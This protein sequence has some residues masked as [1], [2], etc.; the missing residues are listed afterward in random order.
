MNSNNVVEFKN[1]NNKNN[2]IKIF[3]EMDE[4]LI[5]YYFHYEQELKKSGY[6]RLDILNNKNNAMTVMEIVTERLL[7][8]IYGDETTER[9]FDYNIE[10]QQ[11]V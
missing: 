9:F 3:Q 7:R 8:E 11:K 2:E 4:L 1:R 6:S 10:K 5:E